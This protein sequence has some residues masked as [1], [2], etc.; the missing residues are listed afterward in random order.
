MKA[1]AKRSFWT[2]IVMV[3]AILCMSFGFVACDALGGLTRG[4]SKDD[5]EAEQTI[6]QFSKTVTITVTAKNDIT[7]FALK[8]RNGESTKILEFGDMKNGDVLSKTAVFEE[9]YLENNIINVYIEVESG[10]CK[11]LK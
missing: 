6:N 8:I 4:V 3:L 7:D 10:T 2:R 5:Y 11:L 1:Y 9:F